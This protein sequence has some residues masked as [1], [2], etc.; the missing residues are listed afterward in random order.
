MNETTGKL[1]L[2]PLDAA[3]A[4]L[5]PVSATDARLRLRIL[6][7]RPDEAQRAWLAQRNGY[8]TILDPTSTGDARLFWQ[9]R[10]REAGWADAAELR[11]EM[12]KLDCDAGA[13]FRLIAEQLRERAA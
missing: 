3:V 7:G 10:G 12:A 1:A 13:Y 5:W 2:I 8:A 9:Q 11:R 4:C 6:P